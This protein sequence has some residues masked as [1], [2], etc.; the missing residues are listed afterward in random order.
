[1]I[2]RTSLNQPPDDIGGLGVG[3]ACHNK[4]KPFFDIKIADHD[5][6]TDIIYSNFQA[7]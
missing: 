6:F 5:L 4:T 1:M 2:T 7:T 3:S